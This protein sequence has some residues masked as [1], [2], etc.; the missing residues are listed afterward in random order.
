MFEK[1]SAYQPIGR[2]GTPE[3]VAF[4]ALYLASD[5]G[6]FHT[7]ESFPIVGGKLMG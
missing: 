3:E 1:L 2:M 4:L 6:R 5:E 7:G